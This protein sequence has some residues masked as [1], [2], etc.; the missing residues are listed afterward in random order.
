MKEIGSAELVDREVMMTIETVIVIHG[1]G[2][3]DIRIVRRSFRR[4]T[5]TD[6]AVA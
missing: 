5:K 6:Q 1:S 2:Q 4:S 3:Q